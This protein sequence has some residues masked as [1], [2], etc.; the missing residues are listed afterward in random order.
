MS[1]FDQLK[2]E[3][4]QGLPGN[5]ME[6]SHEESRAEGRSDPVLTNSRIQEP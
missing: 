3:S 6:Q 1:L 2:K 5:R 4:R